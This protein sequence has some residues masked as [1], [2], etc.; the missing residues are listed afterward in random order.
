MDKPSGD[1]PTM[2]H[3]DNHIKTILKIFDKYNILHYS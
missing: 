1:L 3:L 2:Y